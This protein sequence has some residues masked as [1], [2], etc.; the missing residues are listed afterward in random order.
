ML[1]N[2]DKQ[3]CGEG[4][5][6]SDVDY[7][8]RAKDACAQGDAVLG[9]HL[10][11]TAFEKA[12]GAAGDPSPEAVDALK[13]AWDLACDLKERSLAEYIFGKLDPFLSAGSPQ[14]ARSGFSSSP[15]TSSRSSGFPGEIFKMW[16]RRSRGISS[17]L[18]PSCSKWSLSA[19]SRRGTCRLF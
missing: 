16:R 13:K 4:A 10:Y 8:L 7:L 19:I 11:L 17:G 14:S 3:S 5:D 9:M 6:G 18:T 15:S 1:E 2:A 12:A